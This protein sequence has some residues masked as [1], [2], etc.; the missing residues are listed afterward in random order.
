MTV[1]RRSIPARSNLKV[2]IS[3]FSSSTN[4]GRFSTAW[5]KISSSTPAK[6]RAP[7]SSAGSP[8]AATRWSHCRCFLPASSAMVS[9]PSTAK[10][11]RCRRTSRASGSA[12]RSTP[13]PPRFSSAAC[14]RT[15][16]GS[17]CRACIG[18]R[19]PPIARTRMAIRRRHR[20]SSKSRSNRTRPAIRRANFWKG[21][22]SRRSSAA[23]CRR[24][25]APTRTCGGCS[26]ISTPSSSTITAARASSRSCIS[27]P[28]VATCTR[29]IRSSPPVFSK[30]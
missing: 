9:S 21:T 8:P 10:Q 22:T 19:A 28:C 12:F 29:D 27:S 7:R 14:C 20:S 16:M 15:S 25:F 1:C 11:C 5:G 26:R 13:R 4:R 17:I 24:R 18:C 2:S 3:T 6:C 23:A 30:R